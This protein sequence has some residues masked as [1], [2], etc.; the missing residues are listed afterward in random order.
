M[1]GLRPWKLGVGAMMVLV[2]ALVF[3]ALLA[4]RRNRT[5]GLNETLQFDDFFFTV[6]SVTPL[7]ADAG[8]QDINQIVRL[9]IEN[10]AKR[11]PFTFNGDSLIILDLSGKLPSA[12]PRAERLPTGAL[13]APVSHV[14]QA[15]E[16]VSVD[17][18]FALPPDHANLRLRI[19]PGGP[20]GD[21]L[22]GMFFGRQ[23]FQLP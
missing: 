13:S 7:A 14:L 3:L 15:G 6:E 12:R 20:V 10:R 23:E 2:V 9:R 18:V 5:L 1:S 21:L 17:Y 22:E 11:V 16:T 4:T 19:M 8:P